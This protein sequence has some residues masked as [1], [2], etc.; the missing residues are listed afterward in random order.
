MVDRYLE[1]RKMITNLFL[2]DKINN[3]QVKD[4]RKDS[5]KGTGK[6]TG[7]NTQ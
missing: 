7:V 1:Q 2:C 3:A 6:H 4:T 5:S